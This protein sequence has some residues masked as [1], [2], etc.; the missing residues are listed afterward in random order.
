LLG[1]ASGVVRQ[2]QPWK[3]AGAAEGDA[4]GARARDDG[5]GPEAGRPLRDR[6][7]D[8]ATANTPE[9]AMALVLQAVIDTL[10]AAAAAY[11]LFDAKQR[12][13]HLAAEVGISDE[14]AS[15]SAGRA[16]ASP[17]GGTCRSTACSTAAPT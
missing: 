6:L 11:C 14:G 5:P 3:R 15:T 2:V 10:G 1:Q 12:A 8:I 9:E 16:R 13:L 17:S 4:P 7:K